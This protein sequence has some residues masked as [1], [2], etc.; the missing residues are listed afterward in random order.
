MKVVLAHETAVGSSAAARAVLDR[1]GVA[2]RLRHVGQYVWRGGTLRLEVEDD[3]PVPAVCYVLSARWPAPI[4]EPLPGPDQALAG[5]EAPVLDGRWMRGSLGYMLAIG[6]YLR[7]PSAI[8]VRSDRP[9]SNVPFLHR[10]QAMV[11]HAL[12]ADL[13]TYVDWFLD[14]CAPVPRAVEAA[15]QRLRLYRLDA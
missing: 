12:S 14:T 8:F 9:L 7:V 10:P 4:L 5:G 2:D 13:A 6:L 1:F 3:G 11:E 15:A